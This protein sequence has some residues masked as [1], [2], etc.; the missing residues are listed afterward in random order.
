MFQA[1]VLGP[2]LR[3]N[4][5]ALATYRCARIGELV[6]VGRLNVSYF[7]RMLDEVVE[8]FAEGAGVGEVN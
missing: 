8:L 2:S 5:R 1:V 6:M 4:Q 7:S 3:A